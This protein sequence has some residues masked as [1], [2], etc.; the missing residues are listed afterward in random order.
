MT[1][2]PIERDEW[3][4]KIMNT[5]CFIYKCNSIFEYLESKKTESYTGPYFCTIKAKKGSGIDLKS[6][7]TS[8]LLICKMMTYSWSTFAT[9]PKQLNRNISH[10][11]FTFLESFFPMIVSAPNI[12]RFSGLA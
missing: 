4:A 11:E 2:T 8:V 5:N 1:E 3:L 7:T 10:Y 6:D 12:S 9:I